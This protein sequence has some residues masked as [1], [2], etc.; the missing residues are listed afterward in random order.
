[1]KLGA[2]TVFIDVV[3]PEHAVFDTHLQTV[4]LLRD[5]SHVRD[6]TVSE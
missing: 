3:S 2:T 4:E 1:M 6:Y 5:P